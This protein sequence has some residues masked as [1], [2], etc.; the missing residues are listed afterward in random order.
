MKGRDS[1]NKEITKVRLC[2]GTDV[3]NLCE[4]FSRWL[5]PA[6]EISG[7]NAVLWFKSNL[8]TTWVGTPAY[9]TSTFTYTGQ[10]AGIKNGGI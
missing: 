2:S 6:I 5:H 4:S 9:D 7:S 10:A 8:N 3:I 1:Y